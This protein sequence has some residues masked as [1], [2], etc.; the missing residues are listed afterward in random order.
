MHGA[1]LILSFVLLATLPGALGLWPLYL[2]APLILYAI[3]VALVRELR[4]TCSWFQVGQF[5]TYTISLTGAFILLSSSGLALYQLSLAPDLDYL[6]SRLPLGALGGVFL[7][8][9]LFS[10][11]NA[12]LEEIIFRGVL[13]YSVEAY[14]GWGTAVAVTAPS[15]CHNPCE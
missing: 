7:G 10:L 12:L 15:C 9:A 5:N 8:G 6:R 2:L 13:F 4:R 3:V 14:W 11:V 1:L